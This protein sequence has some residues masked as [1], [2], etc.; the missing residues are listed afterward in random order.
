MV[1]DYTVGLDTAALVEWA[2][3]VSRPAAYSTGV[4][5]WSKEKYVYTQTL[6]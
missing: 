2:K 1:G 5:L 4:I 6:S 3:L